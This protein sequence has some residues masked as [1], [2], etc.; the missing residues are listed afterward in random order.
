MNSL[1][2]LELDDTAYDLFMKVL[3]VYMRFNKTRDYEQGVRINMFDDIFLELTW[4]K[5][6]RKRFIKTNVL[7]RRDYQVNDEDMI[8]LTKLA[9]FFK[10]NTIDKLTKWY[11]QEAIKR[12][13]TLLSHTVS[14]D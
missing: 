7:H 13:I 2:E 6:Y 12:G 14:V 8:L 4:G 10:S 5:C 11:D 9:D 3:P 1:S